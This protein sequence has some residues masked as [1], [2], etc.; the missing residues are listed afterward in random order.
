MYLT[1][2]NTNEWQKAIEKLDWK[3]QLQTTNLVK[4]KASTIEKTKYEALE[5]LETHAKEVIE[6]SKE[7]REFINKNY[8][9]D[10]YTQLVRGEIEQ[11]ESE[12][13]N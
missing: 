8:L 10:E 1:M 11:D 3:L 2:G 9:L 12:S 7:L 13:N 4:A 6:I 5:M